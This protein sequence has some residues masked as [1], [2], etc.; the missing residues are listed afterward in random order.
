MA[1]YIKRSDVMS[2]CE[3]YSQHCFETSDG[4]G[5]DIADRILDDVCVMP[6]A[7]VVEVVRCEKC[8]FR[9]TEDC[10]RVYWLELEGDY[11]D[12]TEDDDFCSYGERK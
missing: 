7:D 5:Q 4:R 3:S 9:G 1:E 8:N 12:P 11:V 6:V 2:I 10:P